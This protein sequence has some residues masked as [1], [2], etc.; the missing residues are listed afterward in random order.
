[1]RLMTETPNHISILR[2]R[3]GIVLFALFWLP[4][5][6]LAPAIGAFLGKE[7]QVAQITI[8]IMC[9][10]CAIGLLGALIAGKE[11]VGLLKK[12]PRKKIPKT[13]WHLFWSGVQE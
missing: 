6:L 7:S 1:M 13:V 5:Y 3:V 12:V 11:V 2:L 8:F 10:Q 9:I 4:A